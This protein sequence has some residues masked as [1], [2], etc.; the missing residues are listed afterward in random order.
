MTTTPEPV[1]QFRSH[2]AASSVKVDIYPE[3]KAE[4]A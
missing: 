3:R 1:M 4:R 2:V